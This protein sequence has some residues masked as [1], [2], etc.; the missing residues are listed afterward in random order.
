MLRK[1]Q[2]ETIHELSK[3][4][5]SQ[6]TIAHMLG[7]DRKTVW[8]HLQKAVWK[9]YQRAPSGYILMEPFHDW[10]L[11]RAKE[12]N[13]NVS[14]LFR[15]LKLKG[16]MGS[17]E[18]VKKCVSS[19]RSTQSKACVR[20]ETLPGEQ[21]Q[22]DW[23]SALVWIAHVLTR[24]HFFAMVLGYSRRL[25]AKAYIN[26]RFPSLIDGHESAFRHFGGLTHQILYDNAKTM[27]LVHERRNKEHILN[28]DFKDFPSIMDLNHVFA[29]HIVLKQKGRLSQV[30]SML[31]VTSCPE[32]VFRS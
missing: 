26:E 6:R 21:A 24:I 27:I 1:S 31:S 32:G 17:Y 18:T 10:L 2:Y 3:V 22:V 29:C 5:H 25:F 13:Y 9:E 14:V 20:F 12:V 19:L 15:E 30:L 4:G 8:R 7:V 11:A 16:Y 23:G 28:Q